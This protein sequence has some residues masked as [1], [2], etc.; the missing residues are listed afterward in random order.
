MTEVTKYVCDYCGEEFYSK[1]EC[2]R[3]ELEELKHKIAKDV[4]ITDE[5]GNVLT[6]DN[7]NYDKIRYI[8]IYTKEAAQVINM[9]LIEANCESIRHDTS[10]TTGRF[11]YDKELVRWFS[12]DYIEEKYQKAAKIFNA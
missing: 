3:H 9:L 4:Y 12:F 8:A 10:R 11:Y 7:I 5:D 6:L 1:K 2:H